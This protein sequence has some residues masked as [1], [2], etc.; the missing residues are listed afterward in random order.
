M[1]AK[2]GKPCKKC[3]TSRWYKGG[4]CVSCSKEC[5]RQWEI[6]NK[7]KR[8]ESN[9]RWSQA[10][11]DK[12]AAKS[13]RWRAENPGK[14]KAVKHR[15]RARKAEA[16]GDFTAAEWRALCKQ[17]DNRC[18]CCGKKKKLEFDHVRPISEGGTSDISNAQPLCRS[19]NASKG[20][21]TTDYRTKQGIVRWVQKRLRL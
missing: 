6:K 1:T 17:Y 15:R 12:V 7:A 16:G 5:A 20:E 3:G 19:C 14:A 18:A 2:N 13:R 11:P 9:R 21:K 10:N 8:A 4:A